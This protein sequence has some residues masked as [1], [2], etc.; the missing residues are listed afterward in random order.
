M[1]FILITA[2]ITVVCFALSIAAHICYKHGIGPKAWRW[3]SD[4]SLVWG[5]IGGAG[6]FFALV[7]IIPS[8]I[9]NSSIMADTYRITYNET[10]EQLNNTRI[11][12]LEA[13]PASIE[14]LDI[15]S[16]NEQVREFKSEILTAQE[17]L[18]NP[19]LNTFTCYVYNEFDAN[20]VS[21]I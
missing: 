2:I 12:L 19:W 11:R 8:L 17:R 3:D 14:R 16:Y 6:L 5:V 18:K 13:D 21:Y 4:H 15:A 20:V 9:E 1:L 7:C 10:K